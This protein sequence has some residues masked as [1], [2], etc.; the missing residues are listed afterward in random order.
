MVTAGGRLEP[1]DKGYRAESF[2]PAIHDSPVGKEVTKDFA[3]SKG[4]RTDKRNVVLPVTVQNKEGKEYIQTYNRGGKPAGPL[5]EAGSTEK[6][7]TYIRFYPDPNGDREK[8]GKRY[9]KIY[10][11]NERYAYL[12][13]NHPKYLFH[14]DQLDLELQGVR[15]EDIKKIYTPRDYLKELRAKTNLSRIEKSS[16]ELCDLF[17]TEGNLKE[18]DIGITGSPMVGLNKELSDIDLIIYGTKTSL[19]FQNSLADILK[20]G[21]YCREYN[22]QEYQVHYEWRVGG[23]D[24][25]F[26]KFYECE[27]RKLHQ[28][29]YKGFEFFI[30]YIKSPEDWKGSHYDYKYKNLGKIKIKARILDSTESIFTPCSYKINSLKV[31]ECDSNL[32]NLKKEAIQEVNSYRG[33]FC[34]HAE[35]GEEVFIVGKLEKVV[36]RESE[37]YFRILLS[38]QAEDKMMKI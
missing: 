1:G 35:D 36:Y 9:K 29:M 24:I 37:E 3:E 31:L 26:D 13:K 30:R 19:E 22:M 14:S 34:E 17:I 11:L 33:R 25:P 15:N 4:L 28:G 5:K 12:K 16:V 10:K 7:G 38:N 32:E 8:D 23:S 27:R 20:E 21:D 2:N 18:G 6:Q